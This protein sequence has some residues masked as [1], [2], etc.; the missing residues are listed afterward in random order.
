MRAS[1][2]ATWRRRTGLVL[3]V[4]CRSAVEVVAGELDRVDRGQVRVV[5]VGRPHQ[6]VFA[7]GSV[8]PGAPGRPGAVV[9]IVE[10]GGGALLFGQFVPAVAVE[11]QGRT[12]GVPA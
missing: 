5:G 11:D 10:A 7:P 3:V 9:L 12:I 4:R 8:P 1:G 2:T 6:E